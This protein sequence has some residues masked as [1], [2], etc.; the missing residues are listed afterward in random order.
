MHRRSAG[1]T[2]R[3]ELCSGVY[4]LLVEPARKTMLELPAYADGEV[5][6]MLTLG[7]PTP[8]LMP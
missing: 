6:R 1:S 3:G 5:D 7:M 8:L 4:G 2:E